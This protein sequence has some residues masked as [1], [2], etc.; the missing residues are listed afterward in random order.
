MDRV[1]ATLMSHTDALGV[2]TILHTLDA[3]K[4]GFIGKEDILSM[5]QEL[6]AMIGEQQVELI[7]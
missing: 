6:G 2:E 4:D 3:D 7:L 1:S 5:S